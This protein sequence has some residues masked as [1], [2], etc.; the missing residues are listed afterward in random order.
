Y[1]YH[2]ERF[3]MGAR[4]FWFPGASS[5]KN[6]KGPMV[7]ALLYS[8]RLYTAAVSMSYKWLR[9]PGRF[10]LFKRRP[11]RSQLLRNRRRLRSKLFLQFQY[12]RQRAVPVRRR[13]QQRNRDVPV[14]RSLIWQ[15]VFILV[16]MI[17]VQVQRCN[18]LLHGRKTLLQP[19]FRGPIRQ[20]RVPN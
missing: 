15:Q 9:I 10:E 17:V 12:H 8:P 2:L 19:L 1:R 3:D 5:L 6:E 13:L 14:N 7:S 20:V 16:A 18:Q 4:R 11:R